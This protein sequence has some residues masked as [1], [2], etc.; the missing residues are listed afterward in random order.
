M[1]VVVFAEN[2]AV[3]SDSG[4]ARWCHDR[5][6]IDDR[7]NETRVIT[8]SQTCWPAV[9]AAL[10]DDQDLVI[11]VRSSHRR[12]ETVVRRVEVEAEAVPYSRCV[13]QARG[14][15]IVAGDRAV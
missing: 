11:T 8:D 10:D 1:T 15:R 4:Y 3:R 7:I 5:V 12:D 14:K 13:V 9:V 6:E 2:V